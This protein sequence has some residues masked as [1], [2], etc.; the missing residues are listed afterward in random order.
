MAKSFEVKARLLQIHK[1]GYSYYGNPH[2]YITIET[3]DSRRAEK[4]YNSVCR[5]WRAVDRLFSD[6]LEELQEIC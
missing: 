1:K 2:Y 3:E 4:I 5:E 6:V